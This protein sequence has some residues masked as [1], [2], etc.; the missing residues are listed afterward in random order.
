MNAIRALLLVQLLYLGLV[1]W[2]RMAKAGDEVCGGGVCWSARIVNEHLCGVCFSTDRRCVGAGVPENSLCGFESCQIPYGG[3]CETVC[4]TT[5]GFS[6]SAC[7]ARSFSVSCDTS[8]GKCETSQLRKSCS[9]SG[10]SCVESTRADNLGCCQVGG[11]PEP[12]PTSN[13]NLNCNWSCVSAPIAG[14]Q[15]IGNTTDCP[16]G[17]QTACRDEG[18]YG[19]GGPGDPPPAQA[20]MSL[21]ST[22]CENDP[23]FEV[24]LWSNTPGSFEGL[25][26]F[27][28]PRWAPSVSTTLLMLTG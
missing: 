2:V 6:T 19:G 15:C 1:G 20:S 10:S 24:G 13:P 8:A 27:T 21:P 23:S 5:V 25:L 16:V 17:S 18:C 9:M 22:I 4:L 3:T 28:F 14:K 12:V 26:H 11:A 7:E